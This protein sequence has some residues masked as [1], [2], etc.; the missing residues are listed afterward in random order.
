MNKFSKWM[1]K[2]VKK[3]DWLDIGCIKWTTFA[4]ALMIAKLWPAILGLAWHWYLIIALVIA[5]R[6]AYRVYIK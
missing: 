1:G 3:M 2:K 6:T 5:S 4:L